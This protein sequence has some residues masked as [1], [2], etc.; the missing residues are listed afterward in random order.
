MNYIITG[1]TYNSK[2]IDDIAKR[3]DVIA[4]SGD[5]LEKSDIRFSKED[6]VYVPSETSLDIVLQ[7]IDGAELIDNINKL[8]NKYFCREVLESIY[9][10]FY[11]AKATLEEL[12]SLE[13]G[14][15]KV[16]IKPLKGFFGTGVRFAD[17]STDIVALIEDMRKEVEES[18]K[19]F[20]E[21]VLTKNEYIIEEFISGDEYAVDMF[22][23]SEGKPSVMNIYLHPES[24]VADYFHLMYYTNEDI[25]NSYLDKFNQ[26]FLE[27]NKLMNLKNFPIHAEFKLQDGV[28]VPIEL[29]PLRYG[30]FGLSDLTYNSFELQPITAYFDDVTP[31]WNAIWSERTN[32]NYAWVL[33]YNG[34][35]IDV[36]KQ[37]P[38]H[39]CF[40]EFLQKDNEIIDYVKL[41]HQ[42][43]PVFALAYIKNNSLDTMKQVLK[44][45][46]NDFFE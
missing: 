45:E 44:T 14:D 33:G 30:G 8:K 23:D 2:F 10:D 38:K 18:G 19:F 9:P 13:L 15:K 22:F 25:F 42:E 12:P 31:D 28:M 16:V 7:R 46:F 41:N 27:F 40:K 26:F 17:K 24:A 37:T 4:M 32:L 1:K 11:Y 36:M 6:L 34:N 21:A 43:N 5:E 29:N 39:S 35:R 20:S 3:E